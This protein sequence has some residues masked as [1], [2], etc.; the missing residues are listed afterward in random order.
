MLDFIY[1]LILIQ[2]YLYISFLIILA[3]FGYYVLIERKSKVTYSIL[4]GIFLTLFGLVFFYL[5]N[6]LEIQT[7]RED[8]ESWKDLSLIIILFGT[9]YSVTIMLLNIKSLRKN[10]VN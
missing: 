6:Q 1:F 9:I 3:G 8:L 5:L 2:P 7:F 10:N 4:W